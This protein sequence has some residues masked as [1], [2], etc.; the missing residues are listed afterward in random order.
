LRAVIESS[1]DALLKESIDAG[2]KRRERFFR[3]LSAQRSKHLC[4]SELRANCEPVH[5]SAP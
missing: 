3:I 1:L 4:L 5:P 2:Q